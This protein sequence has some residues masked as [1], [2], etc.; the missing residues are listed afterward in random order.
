M[1][2]SRFFL[3]SEISSHGLLGGRRR[4]PSP[5]F[6]GFVMHKP[7]FRCKNFNQIWSHGS[8]GSQWMWWH[9]SCETLY[10]CPWSLMVQPAASSLHR[11]SMGFRRLSSRIWKFSWPISSGTWKSHCPLSSVTPHSFSEAKHEPFTL[12]VYLLIKLLKF[13][14]NWFDFGCSEGWMSDRSGSSGIVHQLKTRYR[15]F[16][17]W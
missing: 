5:D 6:S 15:I 9:S 3:T 12:C 1:K 13:G 7:A 4:M 10:R 11:Y 16:L 2:E 14:L 17:F 8:N